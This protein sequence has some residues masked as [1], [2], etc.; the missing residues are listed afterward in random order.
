[1]TI[2]TRNASRDVHG[3]RAFTYEGGVIMTLN[4]I[5]DPD[6]IIQVQP[7]GTIT[8][9]QGIYAPELNDGELEGDEW[10]LLDGWSGQYSYRGPIMHPSEYIGGALADHIIENP[11][12][13]VAVMNY[14]DDDG[15]GNGVEP[16][17]WA[18]AFKEAEEN[19]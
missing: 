12:Y 18:V 3:N 9:P 1:V 5:M 11:G 17:G 7:D 14:M 2:Y 4:D 19:E 8:E 10:S 6:H 15:D 13:Y 16:D